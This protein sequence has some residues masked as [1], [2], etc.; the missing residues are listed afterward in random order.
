[1]VLSVYAYT[2][3]CSCWFSA[4]MRHLDLYKSNTIGM[5]WSGKTHVFFFTEK[6]ESTRQ[7]VNQQYICTMYA[8]CWAKRVPI[9]KN[10][11][12]TCFPLF[13]LL[14]NQTTQCHMYNHTENIS[15]DPK[16]TNITFKALSTYIRISLKCLHVYENS[17]HHNILAS[18][19]AKLKHVFCCWYCCDCSIVFGPNEI[20]WWGIRTHRAH[21]FRVYL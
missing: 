12:V 10:R 11:F 18:I 4:C 8:I 2:F 3:F 17:H 9:G 7:Y 1:M 5:C 15:S 6:T 14:S 21:S 16:D 19:V 13:T 20:R